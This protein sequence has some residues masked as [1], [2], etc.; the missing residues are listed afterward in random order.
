[1]IPLPS[2]LADQ[3][4]V[5]LAH[6]PTPLEPLDR[7]SEELG[8]PRIWLN[9]D[10]CTGLATGGNK[11]RKLEFLLAAALQEGATDIVTFGAVQSNHVRQTAAACAKLGLQCHAFLSRR[12]PWDHP[13]YERGGNVLMDQML[14]A[15]LHIHDTEDTAN[16]AR[17]GLDALRAANKQVYVI[18][19]GGSN[20]VGALGYA[21]CAVELIAQCAELQ[22][23]PDYVVHASASAGTQAGLVYGLA[24]DDSPM[25]SYGVNV[26]HPQ[27]TTLE[28][29]VRTI[30]DDMH[31]AYGPTSAPR[32]HFNHRYLGDGYGLPHP[33]AIDAM[34]LTARLEGQVFDPVYSGKA[35]GALVDLIS[36]GE[37]GNADDIVFIHTGGQ[38][39]LA[40]YDTAF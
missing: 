5:E 10:D 25:A 13:S 2:W 1:M 6:Q 9:R 35:L 26:F 4:R 30:V 27:G 29:R 34:K 3:P 37:L 28:Q 14:G 7:L 24:R 16:A 36:V 32:F 11:T 21:V 40:A 23:Q 38:A 17:A 15:T 8:G 33:V 20:A 12:V 19:A 22:I 39:A 18:P 31:T